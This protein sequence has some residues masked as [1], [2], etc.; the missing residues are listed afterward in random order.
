MKWI[1]VCLGLV[2]VQ[3]CGTASQTPVVSALRSGVQTL[4]NP[5]AP[6]PALAERRAAILRDVAQAG[7]TAPVLLVTLPTLDAV[8]SLVPAAEN[9]DV[10]TW[11]DPSGV[12]VATRDGLVISTRGLGHD[13][14]ASDVS[15]TQ[16]ALAG[17]PARFD[18]VH[19][20][21]NGENQLLRQ[22]FTCRTETENAGVIER[23]SDGV[24]AFE[25]RFELQ[26]GHIKR[27]TQWLGPDIGF[28][29]LERLR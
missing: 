2:V 25:N 29:T 27:S 14:M 24:T 26:S 28:A 8:A 1:W 3:S 12:S 21:L 15:G 23:C 5:P 4:V 18:R 10:M 17:G 19:R 16:A 7:G 11:I 22:T 13:L 20:Y 9:Q 6:K